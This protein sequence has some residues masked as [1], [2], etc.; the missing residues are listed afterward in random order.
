MDW[1]YEYAVSAVGLLLTLEKKNVEE[2]TG[3]MGME[4]E[5]RK[6]QP[7]EGVSFQPVLGG[8]VITL[9]AREK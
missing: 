2:G 5:E 4:S 1:Q 8:G 3:G 9:N 7:W 6:Q